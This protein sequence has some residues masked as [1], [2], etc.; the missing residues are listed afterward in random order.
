M[1][2]ITQKVNNSVLP[3]EFVLAEAVIE[4]WKQREAPMHKVELIKAF[5]ESLRNFDGNFTFTLQETE[6]I[7]NAFLSTL[8]DQIIT[9]GR[10]IKLGS[11]GIIYLGTRM[12][13]VRP[14]IYKWEKNTGEAS[15]ERNTKMAAMAAKRTIRIRHSH[16][17]YVDGQ[18]NYIDNGIR[19][20]EE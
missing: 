11:I 19:F 8:S 15:T 1:S 2:K 12:P 13:T 17:F 7:Y 3:P 20:M 18:G 4:T 5:Q 16:S 6:K 14:V 9:N 10:A